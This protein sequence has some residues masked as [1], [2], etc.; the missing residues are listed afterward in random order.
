MVLEE[1]RIK[2]LRMVETGKV[3][4]EEAVQLLA[5]LDEGSSGSGPFPPNPPI[6]PLSMGSGRYFRVRVTDTCTGKTRVN[7]RMPLNVITAGMKMGMRFTPEVQGLN[8]EELM[9]AVRNGGIGQIVDIQ[10][11]QDGEHVEV[12][13]E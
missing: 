4:A 1:E 7:L 5:A 13:I 2:V 11:E 8:A 9:A 6:P 10:D 12:F 3:S